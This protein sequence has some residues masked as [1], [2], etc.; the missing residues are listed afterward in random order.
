VKLPSSLLDNIIP[1]PTEGVAASFT[2]EQIHEA[3]TSIS[4][5]SDLLGNQSGEE[6]L[7]LMHF[8]KS[9]AKKSKSAKSK[10]K[11]SQV[12]QRERAISNYEFAKDQY[13]EVQT[14]GVSIDKLA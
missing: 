4:D 9:Q 2:K 3:Q 7:R 11:I 10:I 5:Q 12:Q 1:F 14:V 6:F 13:L 8:V